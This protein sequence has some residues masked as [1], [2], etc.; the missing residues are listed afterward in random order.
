MFCT[1]IHTHM[2]TTTQT[3]HIEKQVLRFFFS[4]LL[5]AIIYMHSYIHTYIYIYMHTYIK[6]HANTHKQEIHI[7]QHRYMNIHIHTCIHTYMHTTLGASTLG[8]ITHTDIHTHIHTDMYMNTYIY[9]ACNLW[10]I[11]I[12][13]HTCIVHAYLQ[14]AQLAIYRPC[15]CLVFGRFGFYHPLSIYLYVC[16]HG[17]Q[18]CLYVCRDHMYV[19]ISDCDVCMYVCMSR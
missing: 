14:S 17:C 9:C 7:K 6:T 18:V 15:C 8:F 3:M 2:I 10:S 4:P 12:Y 1:C 16:M 5:K 11:H 13:I 19:A